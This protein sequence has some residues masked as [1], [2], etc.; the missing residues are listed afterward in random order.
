MNPESE[1]VFW[2]SY[3]PGQQASNHGDGILIRSEIDL[4]KNPLGQ[5][6]IRFDFEY[7]PC[8]DVNKYT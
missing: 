5:Q 6:Q 7:D 1:D 8:I 4:G 2:N 3:T